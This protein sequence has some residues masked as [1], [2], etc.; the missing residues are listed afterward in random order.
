MT[1]MRSRL[2]AVAASLALS[3]LSAANGAEDD[4][5]TPRLANG[6][7]DLN[8]TWGAVPGANPQAVDLGDGG[9]CIFG[10]APA[11]DRPPPDRPTY[12][13]EYQATVADLEARQVDEDPSLTC[14]PPGVP[15]IGPPDKIMQNDSE[16]VFLYDDLNG[17]YWRIVPTD[18]TPHRD[19][20][21]SYLG[22]AIGW[23]EDDTLVVE[24]INLNTLTWLTDDGAFHTGDLRVI[25]RLSRGGDTLHYQAIAY[26]P[27]VLAEPWVLRPREL[28]LSDWELEEP[29]PCIELSLDEMVDRSVH[30]DNVR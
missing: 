26:D 6:R 20:Q 8:G 23:W 14:Q 2:I 7:V 10:C 17:S 13:P 4:N 22:D 27:E 5:A 18:G 28:P 16:L 24:T 15:R 3:L 30:H 25:E 12:K 21:P 29:A 19:S 9:I 11:A 1:D